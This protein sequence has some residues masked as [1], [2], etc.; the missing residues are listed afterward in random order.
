MNI[1]ATAL[2]TA[3]EQFGHEA[4]RPGQERIIKTLL[5]GHDVL[6]LLPTGA[7]KSLTYQLTA[8]LLPGVTIVVSPLIALMQDQ[9]DSLSAQGIPVS[10]INS[11][12][13]RGAAMD[14]LEQV[15]Q[16]KT[17]LLYVTPERFANEEFLN[18]MCKTDVSLFVVDEAHCISEW[19][20]SFRPSYLELPNAIACLKHPTILALTAT[21]TPWIR[22][23]IIQRLGMRA[24]EIVVQG[25][26]RPNLFFAVYRVEDESQDR[27]TLENLLLHAPDDDAPEHERERWQAL[28]G[29]G[30][31][32]TATTNAAK[33]TAEWLNEW[34]IA[35]DYYHGQ[36]KKADRERVQNAFMS[37]ELRVMVATNAFGLGIDKPDVRF[38]IHRDIPGSPEA[39]YQEAGRAGRDGERADCMLIYRPGDLGRAAFLSSGGRLDHDDVRAA[40]PYFLRLE[41]GTR[42]EL[43]EATGLSKPNFDR[44]LK[45]LKQA[46]VV[47][48][49]R[50]RIRV[51]QTDIDP[52]AVPLEDEERRHAYEQSRTEMMRGYA[53]SHDCRREY[54]LTYF[55]EDF[56]GPCWRCDNCV[57]GITVERDAANEPFPLSS[58]VT[59]EAWGGGTVIRYEGEKL[60]VL[61][62]DVGYK[63][64]ALDLVQENDLLKPAA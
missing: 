64:L 26:D 34:G 40:W 31:I 36:R 9:L 55:G 35:A 38:V 29:S 50:G 28:Q 23:E 15:R 37:G 44:L 52:E 6:A 25:V 45:A 53:E 10:V 20:H 30:I 56:D 24:P 42:H 60:V 46:R 41:N 54:L 57:A 62:D 58:R 63:S 11:T 22:E 5:D 7:G 27:R 61:F 48:E 49:R 16:G 12:Q 19:G 14:A 2:A 33:E 43:Q 1:S 4:F 51:L 32:Y 39:Y 21:A 8:Q 47:G 13:S 3:L 17:R 59:H 18:I